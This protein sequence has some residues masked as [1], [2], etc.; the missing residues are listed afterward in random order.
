MHAIT[1]I[2]NTF[3]AEKIIKNEH[4]ETKLFSY[5]IVGKNSLKTLDLTQIYQ[6]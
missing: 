2:L 3:L 6:P 4:I 1:E 5:V